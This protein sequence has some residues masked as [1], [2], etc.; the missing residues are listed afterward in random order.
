MNLIF[1]YIL[2][3]QKKLAN[4]NYVFKDAFFSKNFTNLNNKYYLIYINYHNT[5]YFLYFYYEVY[6]YLKE[7]ALIGKKQIT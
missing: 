6:Y 7:V 3:R 1:Y 2:A 4:N 5:N